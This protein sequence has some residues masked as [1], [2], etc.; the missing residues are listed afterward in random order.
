MCVFTVEYLVRLL[1]AHA[2]P[3]AQGSALWSTLRFAM[4][5]TS[6]IDLL[7]ILPFYCDL[8]LSGLDMRAAGSCEHCSGCAV[9]GSREGS[10]SVV[11][12]ALGALVSC[13]GQATEIHPGTDRCARP[14]ARARKQ[15]TPRRARTQRRRRPKRRT[16]TSREQQEHQQ[17]LEQR[18]KAKQQ[19]SRQQSRSSQ[20]REQ[21]RTRRP[22]EKKRSKKNK[23]NYS[24]KDANTS[25]KDTQKVPERGT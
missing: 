24:K 23:N 4:R 6:L 15:T 17:R 8:L 14:G 9:S 18:S 25:N 11:R 16:S 10:H 7:A 20:Q 19:Q 2:A 12:A 5:F 3:G 22:H 1:T 13:L 21:Q